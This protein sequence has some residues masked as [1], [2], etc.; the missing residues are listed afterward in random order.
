MSSQRSI[1]VG[2]KGS[3]RSASP[4]GKRSSPPP[5][6]VSTT[7]STPST[8]TFVKKNVLPPTITNY[9]DLQQQH[10][11]PPLAI[12]TYGPP[13]TTTI[14]QSSFSERNSSNRSVGSDS[15]RRAREEEAARKIEEERRGK[16]AEQERVWQQKQKEREERDRLAKKADEERLARIAAE[17]EE[18]RRTP[19][20]K[21][22]RMLKSF[23]ESAK[24][25]A[26]NVS[27]VRTFELFFS[28]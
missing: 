14:T 26:E 10:L 3:N 12:P 21:L 20:E 25:V 6:E 16:F 2:S 1:S 15:D 5:F 27:E 19:T 17:E 7:G 8:S 11:R 24:I 13:I 9:A 23:S 22:E 28:I 4:E 18:K